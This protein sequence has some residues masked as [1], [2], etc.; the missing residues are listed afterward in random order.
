MA[1]LQSRQTNEDPFRVAGLDNNL[2]P[3]VSGFYGL[4]GIS[5]PD[6]LTNGP[7]EELAE[8][9]ESA[10]KSR[11]SWWIDADGWQKRHFFYDLLNTRYFVTHLAVPTTSTLELAQRADDLFIYRSPSA[12]PRAFFT[13]EVATYDLPSELAGFARDGDG[14]PFAA[15][16]RGARASWATLATTRPSAERLVV[17]ATN[18]RLRPNATEFSIDATGTGLVVLTETAR[19]G[20]FVATVDGQRVPWFV[21]NHAFKGVR[22]SSPGRHMV[23]FVYRPRYWNLTLVLA[24][25]GAGGLALV[26]LALA[27]KRVPFRKY[28]AGPIPPQG[29][30]LPT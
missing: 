24:T 5:G 8:A 20:D 27:G 23:S 14:R 4:E 17:P 18:Y 2:I 13:T 28:L 16:H 10:Q 3:G 22:I 7:Y 19:P 11:W 25:L 6:A 9:A 21:I 1:W 15:G 30:A 12:W 29:N 26:F